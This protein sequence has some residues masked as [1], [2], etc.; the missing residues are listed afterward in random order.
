MKRF[1]LALL[2]SGCTPPP[3]T[4]EWTWSLPPGFPTPAVPQDNPMS[5]G[6]VELGRRLFYD[7]RLSANGEQ[8]CASCHEQARAFTDGKGHAVGSTGQHHRRNAQGLGNV[9][10]FAALTWSNP[11]VTTLERQALLPLFGETPVELGWAGKEAELL[12]RLS[13]DADYAARFEASFPGKGV[14]LETLTA[15]L[16]A[17]ERVLLS[18]GSAYDRWAGGAGDAL[19]ADAKAGLDLFNSERLECYHCHTGFTFSDSVSHAGTAVAE[20]PF[21][22]TGL[23]D[24]DGQGSYPGADTGLFEITQRAGDMGRFRAPSLRNLSVTAPYMH[25]GSLATLGEVLDAYAAGGHARQTS[26]RP[27]PLQSD[28]V[29]GFT[30]TADER[31]QLEAFLASLDDPSFLTDERLSDPFAAKP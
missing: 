19:S 6:K 15:G 27:S 20:R 12:A 31:R 25:D 7:V 11:L 28:L 2:A 5:P 9:A 30:L 22:N 14:T 26:G 23:Y 10:Y 1:L 13:G 4:P 29:R 18:G 3:T 17:F 8:S 21:H 16:A 24:V